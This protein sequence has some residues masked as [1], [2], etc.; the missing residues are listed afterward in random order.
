LPQ[1]RG[2][3]RPLPQAYPPALVDH[4]S[5]GRHSGSKSRFTRSSDQR[6]RRSP[7]ADDSPNYS[8][9]R[10]SSA[11]IPLHLRKMLFLAWPL[12]NNRKALRAPSDPVTRPVTCGPN[13]V[14]PPVARLN[15]RSQAP[16]DPERASRH[17][18]AAAH[19][20]SRPTDQRIRGGDVPV[21]CAVSVPWTSR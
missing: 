1:Q 18:D 8:F 2:R 10:I 5:G 11:C 4:W 20:P 19:R 12:P 16:P 14:K 21:A 7:T 15:A 3:G 13:L 9:S 17:P 6:R